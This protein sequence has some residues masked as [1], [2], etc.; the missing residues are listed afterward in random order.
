MIK[1]STEGGMS[2]GVYSPTEKSFQRFLFH[3]LSLM[4]EQNQF[5]QSSMSIG[6][7][8]RIWNNTY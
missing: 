1:M 8:G 6:P 5:R 4:L 2:D 7:P 3:I